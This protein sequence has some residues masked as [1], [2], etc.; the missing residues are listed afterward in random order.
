M[1]P[2]RDVVGVAAGAMLAV[3]VATGLPAQA[4]STGPALEPI[5]LAR[6]QAIRADMNARY[7]A[8]PGF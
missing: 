8:L 6:A 1:E 4:S 3:A 2:R 5:A 7:S